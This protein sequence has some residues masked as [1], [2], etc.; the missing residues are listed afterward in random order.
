M[1]KKTVAVIG[2]GTI[3]ADVALVL[4]LNNYSV[5]LKDLSKVIL[6]KAEKS[7]RDSYR[8]TKMMRK[9]D[10]M[11]SLND[12]LNRIELT[13][14]YEGFQETD[15]VIENIT[16]DYEA[17]KNV[18]LE[19]KKMCR[20]NTI[21]GVNTSCISITKIAALMLV[22][23]NVIGT[24]FMNPVP[25]SKLVE[26]VMGY[27]TSEDTI[28]KTRHLIQTLQKTCIV[29]NDLP[30]FVTNRVMML[31]VNESIWLVHDQVAVA[32][33][34]DMIFKLGFGHKMGPLATADLIGLDT[35]LNSLSVLY[36]N[37]NDPKY[38][39]C[40]LLRKMV[41]AGILGKKSGRGFYNY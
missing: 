14:D 1:K 35:I 27:H 30:G 10:P 37:Y 22:P 21:Y 12:V 18:Y 40:P 31:T 17:K 26:V 19:L 4:S 8:F 39:P 7:I 20:K 24:H 38:R 28:E 9:S 6:D 15:F 36:E 33:D 34:V 5:L 41:E 23:E 13:T 29:V 32:K 11:P 25:L 3:G 2:A 16:E